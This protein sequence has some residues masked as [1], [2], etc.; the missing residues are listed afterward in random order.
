M[1]YLLAIT[2]ALLLAAAPPVFNART[3]DGR[4]VSGALAEW[5]GD[6]L[7]LRS[8][9]NDRSVALSELMELSPAGDDAPAAAG[10]SI[11]VALVDGSVVAA[12]SLAIGAD[13][14]SLRTLDARQLELPAAAVEHVRF[15]QLAP[16]M[17]KQWQDVLRVETDQ[18]MLVVG[19]EQAL[20]YLRGAVR[21]VGAET[22]EFQLE[23]EVL[24][25]KLNKVLAIRFYRPAKSTGGEVLARL[26]DADGS[27]WSVRAASLSEG[28]LHCLTPAGLAIDLPLEAIRRIEFAAANL[29]YLGDLEPQSYTWTPYFAPATEMPALARFFRPRANATI[30]SAPI[31]L[32]GTE[33][34]HG[35]TLHSRTEI[36]YR[37]GEPFTRLQAL[38]GIDDR[39]KPRGNVHLTISGDGHVLFEGDVVGTERARAIEADL[40]G[41]VELKILVDFGADLDI[42]DHLVL[43]E[44]KL[45]K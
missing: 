17:E 43:A 29:V 22:V 18:D 23:G 2:S 42:G 33:H 38:A 13:K 35:L 24:P 21:S 12:T 31:V 5:E 4:Q 16:S 25:V 37:L 15:R 11:R 3:V 30:Y 36:T 26:H 9:G 34:Q 41:V 44:A 40:R 14:A 27:L 8:G 39:L 19:K 20:D 7:T 32:D 1:N 45:L 6:S 10:D 28:R